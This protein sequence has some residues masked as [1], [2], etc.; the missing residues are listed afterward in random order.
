[1]EKESLT[2][3]D[4]ML[5][6]EW[7]EEDEEEEEEEEDEEKNMDTKGD[8]NYWEKILSREWEEEEEEE[9]QCY[10]MEEGMKLVINPDRWKNHELEDVIAQVFRANVPASKIL[11]ESLILGGFKY[12]DTLEW[13][14]RNKITHTVSICDQAPK[15][16]DY[17]TSDR[18]L[19]IN[20]LDCEDVQLD[21]YF[22][23][24]IRF[25]HNARSH[26][27]SNMDKFIPGR[28]YVHCMMGVSRS[29][30]II[31]AYLIAWLNI[32]YPEA[33]YFVLSKRWNIRPNDGFTVQL[34]KWAD[35][36]ARQSLTKELQTNNPV[37]LSQDLKQIG[38]LTL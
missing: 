23:E 24:T 21:K 27:F 25:I 1:M 18:Q 4:E 37:L 12:I 9:F 28:V 33:L 36:A 13:F 5:S 16:P 26:S 17:F 2:Y 31:I 22:V 29:V 32:P 11:G 15:F 3:W 19:H 8:E 6:M 35:S 38:S 30:T 10:D 14:Q 34:T 7:D 20:V